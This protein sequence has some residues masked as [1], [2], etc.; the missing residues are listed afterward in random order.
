MY[1]TFLIRFQVVILIVAAISLSAFGQ[2]AT[3][4]AKSDPTAT[5]RSALLYQ[6][7]LSY[8]AMSLPE[9]Q[10]AL[11]KQLKDGK[12]NIGVTNWLKMLE[13]LRE[14]PKDEKRT[15]SE[16]TKKREEDN[17]EIRALQEELLKNY[18]ELKERNQSTQQGK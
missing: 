10:K 17:K 3:P 2:A 18:P 14:W 5:D 8:L 15:Q 4:E 13:M 7:C 1:P 12:E 11:D 6:Q 9:F 16:K